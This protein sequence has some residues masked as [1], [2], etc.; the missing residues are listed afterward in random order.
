MSPPM[1]RHA[2]VGLGEPPP[3]PVVIVLVVLA[4]LV[5]EVVL[6]VAPPW[7]EPTD[8]AEREPHAAVKRLAARAQDVTP[9]RRRM[10]VLYVR[11]QG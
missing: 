6:V 2:V 11:R 5:P 7:P 1:R 10:S 4:V 8:S 9:Y 3:A